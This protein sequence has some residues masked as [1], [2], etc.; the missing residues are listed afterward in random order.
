MS[1]PTYPEYIESGI[2]WLGKL[3]AHWSVGPLK[4]VLASVES[5]TSVNSFDAPA[6]AGELGILKTSCVYGGSFNENENKRVVAEESHRVTCPLRSNALIV[7]R[8]NTPELVGAAVFVTHARD[9][10]YLPD[11]LWQVS[12]DGA[13]PA[14]AYYWTLAACY[15]AQVQAT[16][17]GTSS[18][19]QNLSQSQFCNF[20]FPCP[21]R[22]EQSAI[23]AFL[24]HETAKIDALIAEQEK[25]IELLKE[26]RQ[27]V[28][29]HAV[30]K[31]LDPNVPMKDSGVEWL[32]EVPEHWAVTKL[33][34]WVRAVQTGGTP[35]TFSPSV[36]VDEGIDWFTPGDFSGVL[37]LAG[38]SK[39]VSVEAVE[40]GEAKIFPAGVV[41]VVGIGAT[42]GKTGYIQTPASANQQ[43]NA[44]FP[45]D[46]VNGL[47][48]A[49][50]LSSKTTEMR[51]LS[52]VSTIGIMNQDKTKEIWV[53][54]PHL[55]EQECISKRLDDDGVVYDTLVGESHNAVS[56]LKE[57]RSALISAAVT[58]KIDVRG[59][60][61]QPEAA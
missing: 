28:I 44:I 37:R 39:K 33:R 3:P 30:T 12:F 20:I 14:F 8:M 18:S 54:I 24:D 36:G 17:T 27:A 9:G 56:L 43:I 5:G 13:L 48:L 2:S 29:S 1:F 21:P 4:R 46:D 19:M 61:P 34:R 49:Y 26:K 41:L 42:L 16:C 55:G 50:S 53:A 7:S 31:G 6:E 10:L 15:R 51:Y 11:R 40:Q 35:S 47:F 25:L 60:A 32:G 38:A 45:S 23:A 58:G 59:Y 57:R 22:Q 52:N